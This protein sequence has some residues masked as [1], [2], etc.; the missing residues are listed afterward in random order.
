MVRD[1]RRLFWNVLSVFGIK[2]VSHWS[3]H[4]ALNYQRKKKKAPNP[5]SLQ[6]KPVPSHYWYIL[7]ESRGYGSATTEI[8]LVDQTP[9][10]AALKVV[11]LL[12]LTD[13]SLAMGSN[14]TSAYKTHEHWNSLGTYFDNFKFSTP[15]WANSFVP[16]VVCQHFFISIAVFCLAPVSVFPSS[17]S[18]KHWP[19]KY[20]SP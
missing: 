11:H 4:Y 16:W 18:V 13:L 15:V 2:A 8:C 3:Q 10:A 7:T 12:S 9:F 19:W 17:M 6:Q 20:L 14:G 1:S 5:P